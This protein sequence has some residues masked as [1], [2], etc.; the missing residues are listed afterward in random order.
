MRMMVS[1]FLWRKRSVIVVTGS[2]KV[3][4]E[5]NASQIKLSIYYSLI[6]FDFFNCRQLQL[7]VRDVPFKLGLQ[8]L[9]FWAKAPELNMSLYRWLKPTAIDVEHLQSMFL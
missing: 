7:T 8:S 3:R 5:K 6:L 1:F 2:N 4:K 9:L